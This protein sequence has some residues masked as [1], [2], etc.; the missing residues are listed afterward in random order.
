M[1]G[2]FVILGASVVILTIL[3]FWTAPPNK[4]VDGR[5]VKRGEGRNFNGNIIASDELRLKIHERENEELK[6][7]SF[8]SSPSGKRVAYFRQKFVSNVSEIGEDDYTSLVIEEEGKKRTVF[9]GDHHLSFFEWLDDNEIAVY[10]DCGT[11]CMMVYLID[12]QTGRSHRFFMGG[13]YSWAPNKKYVLAFHDVPSDG[14][15]VGDKFGNVLFS[16]VRENPNTQE[17]VANL[18]AAW[19]PDSSKIALIVHKEL[20]SDLELIVF[21]VLNKFKITLRKDLPEKEFSELNWRATGK[22]TYKSGGKEN[23]IKL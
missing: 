18:R 3:L 16:L 23:S 10:Q 6:G 19:S 20:S 22:L 15:S 9:S 4:E 17:T 11:E 7:R 1:I 8:L 21:N 14:I 2:K 13:G 12:T 5:L